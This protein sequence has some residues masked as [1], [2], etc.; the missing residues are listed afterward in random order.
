MKTTLT[1]FIGCF[2]AGAV[3]AGESLTNRPAAWAQP[4]MLDGI[5]NF[6][7]VSTTREMTL[8]GFGFHE[9]WQNLPDWIADLDIE[10]IRRDAGIK[11]GTEQQRSGSDER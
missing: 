9:V 10:S 8:G 3:L 5:P 2:L 1:L 4:V 7:Q 11:I 6:H